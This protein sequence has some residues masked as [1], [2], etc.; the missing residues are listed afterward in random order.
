MAKEQPKEIHFSQNPISGVIETYDENGQYLGRM[1]TMGD[2]I[3]NDEQEAE[4]ARRIAA[5]DKHA[6]FHVMANTEED[7]PEW[8]EEQ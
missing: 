4:I 2:F 7:P 5:G 8:E 1:Y 6:F 3:P